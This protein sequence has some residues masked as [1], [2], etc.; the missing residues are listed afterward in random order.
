MVEILPSVLVPL[1]DTT[2]PFL[3]RNPKRDMCFFS[4]NSCS[5]VAINYLLAVN[6]SLPVINDSFLQ[7]NN[8]FPRINHSFPTIIAFE[9]IIRLSDLLP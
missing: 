3:L 7:S 6:N 9:W 5:S 2:L 4:F 8:S 1:K